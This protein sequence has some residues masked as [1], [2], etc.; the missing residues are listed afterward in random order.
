MGFVRFVVQM[1][2]SRV[3]SV[4]VTNHVTFI[5]RALGFSRTGKMAAQACGATALV[6]DKISPVLLEGFFM[7]MARIWIRVPL[8]FLT[9]RWCW[10]LLFG[11][12]CLNCSSDRI[13]YDV[14]VSEAPVLSSSP[15]SL[16]KCAFA[17]AVLQTNTC[18][19]SVYD[20]FLATVVHCSIL[21]PQIL[22]RLPRL[23]L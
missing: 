6:L 14:F 11:V 17:L 13:W 10:H 7:K 23:K 15:H 12:K 9:F 22:A 5:T 20:W 8:E 2:F 4:K 18:P 16:V 21:Q 3:W 1:V 19:S